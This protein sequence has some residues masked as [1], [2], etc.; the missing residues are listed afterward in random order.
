[1]PRR[2]RE[3]RIEGIQQQVYQYLLDLHLIGKHVR[4]CFGNIQPHLN[5]LLS[6]LGRYKPN[7]RLQKLL[8]FNTYK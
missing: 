4:N 8:Y 3:K 2:R 6:R 5:P 1:M 7:Y